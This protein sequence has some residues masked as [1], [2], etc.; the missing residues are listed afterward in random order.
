MMSTAPLTRTLRH[1][2]AGGMAVCVAG[3][4][5]CPS[6][7]KTTP[8]AKPRPTAMTK[9]PAP[10]KP[11]SE[12][13]EK[14]VKAPPAK[15]AKPAEGPPW[16]LRRQQEAA[17]QQREILARQF[18]AEA[19]AWVDKFEREKPDWRVE[20]WGN[21]AALATVERNGEKMLHVVAEA[22]TKDKVAILKALQ[23]DLSSRGRITLDV[24]NAT[25]APVALALALTTDEWYEA[26]IRNVAP[27]PNKA[28][29]FDL[30]AKDF[31]AKSSDWKHSAAIKEFASPK[32]ICIL[33]YTKE[34]GEFYVD[35]LKLLKAD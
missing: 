24:E 4:L 18:P 23:M 30:R 20:A 21:P 8:A 3:L 5:A 14:P 16:V 17:R 11:A 10:A 6:G 32:W 35:N 9:A 26:P 27:G 19:G 1:L 22:G 13:A 31:K 15:P 33:L 25:K 12:S 28:V 29:T 2:A 7:C 34:G